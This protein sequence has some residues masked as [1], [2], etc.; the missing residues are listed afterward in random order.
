MSQV[1]G[2][3]GAGRMG[4]PMVVR[5]VQAGYR[6][7]LYARREKVRARLAEQGAILAESPAEVA[8]GADIVL[9]CLYSDDQLA[10]VLD[11]PQGVLANA[12]RSAIVVSHTTGTA[13]TITDL[14][15]AHPEGPTLVDAPVSGSADD[16][17]A[18]KITILLGGPEYTTS[19]VQ[20]VLA[21]YGEHIITTG[22]TGTALHLKLLNNAVFAATAQLAATAIELGHQLGIDEGQLLRAFS[23]CSASSYAVASIQNTGS[24]ELFS[25]VA[26]PFLRKDVSACLDTAAASGITLE[27]LATTIRTGPLPLS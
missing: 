14:D 25:T 24:L 4:E 2:F 16:I 22:P 7:L 12:S 20:P 19:V 13:T 6:V 17:A 11:G 3:I 15:A 26:A 1:V 21:A 18:G 27:G 10:E 23:V 5:L 9:T 8:A